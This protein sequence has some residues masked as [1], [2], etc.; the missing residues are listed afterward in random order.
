MGHRVFGFEQKLPKNFCIVLESVTVVPSK[1]PVWVREIE[2]RQM[3]P[4]H[5]W[6]HMVNNMKIVV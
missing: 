4:S 2:L 6:V 3:I 5:T 1:I